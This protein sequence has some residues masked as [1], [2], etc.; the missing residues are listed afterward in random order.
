MTAPDL[1]LPDGIIRHD[2]CPDLKRFNVYRNNHVMSLI[3]NLKDGFPLVLAIVSDDFFS[4][5]A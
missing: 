5:M 3:S 1:P 2:G 4:Y